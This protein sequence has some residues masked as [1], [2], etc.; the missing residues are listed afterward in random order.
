[1]VKRCLYV[2]CKLN[3]WKK[4]YIYIFEVETEYLDELHYLHNGYPSAPEKLAM[5]NYCKKLAD[6]YGIN[7]GDVNKLVP[8][9]GNESNYIVHYRNFSCIYYLK[10]NWLKSTKF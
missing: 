3:S 9:L 8:N 5:S 7:V 1:M 6:K 2:W 4:L 10:R